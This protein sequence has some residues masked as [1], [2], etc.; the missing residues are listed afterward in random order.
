MSLIVII[1]E[2]Q[3]VVQ[4][5]SK[6]LLGQGYTITSRSSADENTEVRSFTSSIKAVICNVR[7]GWGFWHILDQND[8]PLAKKFIFM[9]GGNLP[10]GLDELVRGSGQPLLLK[11][12]EFSELEAV[13][14]QIG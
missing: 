7:N 8:E 6:Y 10:Y 5:L 1:E 14:K 13:L 4:A 12:F 9:T 3:D 2:N 11:P